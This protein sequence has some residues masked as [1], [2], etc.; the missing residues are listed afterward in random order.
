MA[1]NAA[2]LNS[3]IPAHSRPEINPILI[4]VI[5]TIATFMEVLDTSIANVALPH[6]AGSLSAGQD[7]SS[8]VLTSYLVA[9]AII[10]PISGWLATFF[11]RKRFY[12]A[13]VVIFV[14]SSF[15][16]GVSTNLG[17]LIFFRILQGLGGGGL[18]PS[19]QSIIADTV[20][21]EKRGLAFAIYGLG[22]VFAP[23]IGPTVGGWIT[24]NYSWH[25]IFFINVPVGLL[26]VI[27]TWYFVNEPKSTAGDRERLKKEGFTVDWVGIG[28]IALGIGSLELVL[29]EGNREDWF[30]S[31]FIIRFLIIAIIALVAGVIWEFYQRHPAVDVRMLLDRNFASSFILLFAVGFILFGSTFLLPL[32]AQTLMGYDAVTAGEVIS[33]GGFVVMLMM[34]LVGGVLL[35]KVQV[36]WLI[37]IGLIISAAALWHMTGLSLD[38]GYSDLAWARIYQAAGLA[39]LFVPINTA[40][41]TG[42]P[43]GKTNNVSALMNLSR[44]LGGSFGIA[45]LSTILARRTQFHINSL[46]YYTSDYNSNVSQWLAK[47]TQYLQSQ[48]SNAFDAAAQAKGVLW[49][50]VIKQSTMLAFLDAYRVLMILIICA[51]PLIFLLKKNKPGGGPGGH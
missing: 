19:E 23:A 47:T 8:W 29:D 42:I 11:G 48:G 46:G 31:S 44:N 49:A 13:C 12:M 26:S 2:D 22:V 39:F 14:A 27:L 51:I 18:A 32:M 15:M 9:N 21:P 3:A 43:P 35:Q 38:A 50:Q 40:A 20:P 25:W 34:P 1:A 36:R 28:L 16:C 33:P 45:I 5:L 10:L 17:M 6:I 7:E 24:D 30:E 4:I 37:L 41:Y